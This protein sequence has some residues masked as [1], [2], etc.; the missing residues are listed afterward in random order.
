MKDEIKGVQEDI[1][2]KKK[3]ENMKKR[4]KIQNETLTGFKKTIKVSKQKGD[5]L[6]ANYSQIE[7]LLNVIQNARSK[8]YPWKEIAKTLKD[9]KKIWDG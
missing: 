8:E 6:Y 5:L 4:L 1:W 3:L 7:N 2:D 9:A